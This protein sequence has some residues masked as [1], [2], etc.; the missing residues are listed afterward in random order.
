MRI[1]LALAAALLPL[2]IAQ[3]QSHVLVVSGI[4]GEQRNIDLFYELGKSFTESARTRHGVAPENVVWLSEDPARN[5]AL[6]GGRSDKETIEK[7]IKRIAGVARPGDHVVLVLI[8]HGS[9]QGAEGKFNMPGPD[10][11]S[12][13]FLALLEPLAA[14]RVAF[15][16]LSSGSGDFIPVLSAPNRVI[17]T[18]TKTGFER[19]EP[20]FPRHFVESFAQDVA[21][22]D[23]DGRISLWEAFDYANKEVKRFYEDDGRLLTEHAMLDD[24]GDKRGTHEPDP[25]AVDGDGSAARTFYIAGKVA[26]GVAARDPRLAPLLQEKAEIEA[27][28]ET[29]RR[30]K[31]GMD[32]TV[33]EQ[34]LEKLLVDLALKTKQIR[35]LG[36][37][38]RRP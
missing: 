6:I 5:G 13:D 8:G 35:D 23:K 12:A 26:A 27:A 31:A 25:R 17:I 24:N 11:G 15:L 9:S 7:E 32:S 19:N 34:Q 38:P 3:A 30:A 22:A 4:G 28:I 2:S 29:L 1:Q 18:A 21:D 37:E 10:L 14:Q 20:H 16:N 36:G 33:Y